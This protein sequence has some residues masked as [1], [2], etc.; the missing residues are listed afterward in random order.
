LWWGTREANSTKRD[1][2]CTLQHSDNDSDG[3]MQVRWKGKRAG[4]LTTSHVARKLVGGRDGD[5]RPCSPGAVRRVGWKY[6]GGKGERKANK[7][8]EQR[9]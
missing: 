4:L 2:R 5:S 7:A 3:A 1:P 6:V 9:Y 8:G